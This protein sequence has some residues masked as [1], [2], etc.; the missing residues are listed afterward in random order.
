[1]VIV[2]I[3]VAIVAALVW[4]YIDKR[5]QQKAEESATDTATVQITNL[6]NVDATEFD[7]FVKDE[8]ATANS[9]ALEASSKYKLAAIVVELP[10]S[11][12][13]NSGTDRY[14]FASDSDSVNN[15]VI[16]F[17]QE[18]QSHLRAL[19]PK[20]DYIGNVPAIDT[21]LW[22]FNFVTALQ[23]AEQN[24]GMGFREVNNLESVTLTLRHME[25]NNWLAWGVEYKAKGT[26]FEVKIDANSGK[27]VE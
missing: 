24:G 2:I 25:P 12:E 5:S 7:Q 15:W 26:S 6:T 19:I 27:V 4:S 9:K 1:V 16:T 18:N 21:S 11:L 20:S 8:Y 17:S 10:A 22:K 14:V 23:I 13:V 3:V